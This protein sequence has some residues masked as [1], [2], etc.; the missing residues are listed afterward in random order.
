MT[1]VCTDIMARDDSEFEISFN[2]YDGFATFK[3]VVDGNDT[4]VYLQ[5]EQVQVFKDKL[6]KALDL[7][8]I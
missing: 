8:T 5:P 7:A 2:K 4:T 3:L 6:A 1:R